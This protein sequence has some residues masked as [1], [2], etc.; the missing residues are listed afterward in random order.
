[1]LGPCDRGGGGFGQR[2]RHALRL[3]ACRRQVMEGYNW[4]HE[5]AVVTL[6]RCVRVF[7]CVRTRAFMLT[8]VRMQCMRALVFVCAR[9]SCVRVCARATA[10]SP[11]VSE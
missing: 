7:A 8:Y 4:S 9:E 10:G 5:N 2:E 6:F 1:M 11:G 3:S